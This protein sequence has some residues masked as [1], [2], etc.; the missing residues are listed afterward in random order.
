LAQGVQ[1]VEQQVAQIGNQTDHI[2]QS[3]DQAL[4]KET[5][6]ATSQDQLKSMIDGLTRMIAKDPTGRTLIN[7]VAL[8]AE[9][10]GA[11]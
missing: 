3:A 6:I 4:A 9:K 7:L 10:V 5:Q 2:A 11:I 1:G 8:I